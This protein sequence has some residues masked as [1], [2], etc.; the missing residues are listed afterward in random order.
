MD[1][2]RGDG[3]LTFASVILI[4]AGIM[5]II[6]SLWAFRYHG[7]L[8]DGLQNALLG[9]SLK[10]YGWW[11]LFVGL[12]LIFAGVAVLGRSQLGRWVGII[13]AAIGGLSAMTW[14]PY[15][16][17][18]S[19]IYVAMAVLVIYGLTAYGARIGPR[20]AE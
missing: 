19:L 8:P 20:A 1:E 6:D 17:V 11:F 3:W 14:I 18:W 2:S 15:Y 5:R 16:P 7:A 12:L 13:A 9:D 10:N 4:F